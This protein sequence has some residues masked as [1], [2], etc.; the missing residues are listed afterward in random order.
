MMSEEEQ[1]R[2][3][4]QRM[5]RRADEITDES[6]ESTRRMLQM[7]EETQDTGIKT[8]VAL[9]EQGEKLNRV[10]ENLDI[11]NADMKEAEK[12]LTGLE[13]FCGLCVCSCRKRP[14][15]EKSEQYRKAYGKRDEFS[16]VKNNRSGPSSSGAKAPSGGYIQRVT[17]DARE[18]E[19]DENIGQV[20]GIV[21]NLKAMAIDMGSELETQNK[22][23]DRI[24]DKTTAN[25]TRIE[26]ANKRA[27]HILRN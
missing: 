6:L 1:M 17:N 4:L 23:I 14:D 11:I 27:E 9:D 15:F 24:T 25:E 10:E 20:A 12:N 7:A 16:D 21:D 2:M 13:K 18:D 22:Q 5:Q 26:S 19:M 3:E 8:L